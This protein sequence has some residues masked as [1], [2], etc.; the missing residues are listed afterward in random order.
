MANRSAG[1]PANLSRLT[2]PTYLVLL[3]ILNNNEIS[4]DE[5]KAMVRTIIEATF[6]PDVDSS[7]VNFDKLFYDLRIAF[8]DETDE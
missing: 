1:I 6:P 4:D 7:K 3:N 5:A 8:R 2:Y